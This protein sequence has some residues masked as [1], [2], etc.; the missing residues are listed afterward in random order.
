MIMQHIRKSLECMFDLNALGEVDILR[1][2]SHHQSSGA[3]VMVG[4]YWARTYDM[5]DM[6]RY[7]NH[8]ATAALV[9][10]GNSV[11]KL[12]MVISIPP[13]WCHTEKRY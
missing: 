10:V 3:S 11:S 6:I 13:I 4:W 12:P 2:V 9:L 7:L 5:P 8:W 1:R